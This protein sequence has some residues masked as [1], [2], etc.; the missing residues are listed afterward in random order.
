MFY[1]DIYLAKDVLLSLRVLDV[2]DLIKCSESP[3]I[4][5]VDGNL[6]LIFKSFFL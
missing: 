2:G 5:F 4:V 1:D 3:C 6:D